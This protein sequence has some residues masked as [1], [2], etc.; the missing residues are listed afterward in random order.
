MATLKQLWISFWSKLGI[1]PKSAFRQCRI[2]RKAPYPSALVSFYAT[3]R[4][5]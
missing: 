5:H 3:K 4:F 1:Y 2:R